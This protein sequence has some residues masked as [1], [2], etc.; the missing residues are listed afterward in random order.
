MKFGLSLST[1]ISKVDEETDQGFWLSKI[2]S[3]SLRQLVNNLTNVGCPRRTVAV[4]VKD[5]ID[6]RYFG[7]VM[8]LRQRI[9]QANLANE[10]LDVSGDIDRLVKRKSVDFLDATGDDFNSKI[11]KAVLEAQ[12]SDAYLNLDSSKAEQIEEI[13]RK[14]RS[15]LRDPER[16]SAE[17]I[18]R[19][20][21]NKDAEIMAALTPQEART[22]ELT[23]TST[24]MEARRATRYL[25]LDN[26][27]FAGVF[28][29]AKRFDDQILNWQ[30]NVAYSMDT[31]P[32]NYDDLL[33][34]KEDAIRQV[35]GPDG[36]ADYVRTS[37]P[38]FQMLDSWVQSKGLPYDV[39][40]AISQ[41]REGVGKAYYEKISQGSLTEVQRQGYLDELQAYSQREVQA[42][43]ERYNTK[44]NP[45]LPIFSWVSTISSGN[46][47]IAPRR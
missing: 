24:A 26:S 46:I 8:M 39:S 42:V 2:A 11:E 10:Q 12:L 7:E 9:L 16:M 44:L 36:F 25:A 29:V 47:P 38:Q 13:R 28:D 4:I 31:F 35:L 27:Q 21:R 14:Y 20:L 17:D 41:I 3:L 37:D 33:H 34:A 19:H 18:A 22:Y 23:E 40:I 5:E 43:L 6:R 45:N 1:N 32:N 15:I 30:L